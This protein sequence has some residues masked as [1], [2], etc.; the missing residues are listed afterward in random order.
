VTSPQTAILDGL[1]EA[2]R[3][4]ALMVVSVDG[5]IAIDGSVGKLTGDADQRLMS[6][7]RRRA[8][9]VVVGGRTVAIQGYAQLSDEQTRQR[10]REAGLPEQP[11]LAIICRDPDRLSNAAPLTGGELSVLMLCTRR[12]TLA[13]SERV[14]LELLPTTRGGEP[15]LRRAAELLRAR[16]PDGLLLWEGGPTILTMAIAQAVLD[17]LVLV[18]SPRLVGGGAR[19]LL[20]GERL[21]DAPVKL[22]DHATAEGFVF[23]RYGLRRGAEAGGAADRDRG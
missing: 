4:V 11:Q 23:L 2:G 15:D 14:A 16:Q 13:S 5:A 19:H 10:R 7:L 12:G 18:V 22:L 3:S 1:Q 9:A 6:E 21:L 17:E 8:A 20:V